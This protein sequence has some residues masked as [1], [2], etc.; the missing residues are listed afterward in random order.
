LVYLYGHD[1]GRR[2]GLLRA[3]ANSRKRASYRAYS[4]TLIARVCYHFVYRKNIV[5]IA[6]TTKGPWLSATIDPRFGRCMYFLFV[7]TEDMSFEAFENANS[8]CGEGEGIQFVQLIARNGAKAVLTG[9]CDPNAHQALR[10][11]GVDVIVDCSGT[12]SEA[13]ERFKSSQLHAVSGPNLG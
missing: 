10:A 4:L 11:A 5:K 1:P 7:E 6:L 8:A 2:V 13:V 9:N 3:E 12:V